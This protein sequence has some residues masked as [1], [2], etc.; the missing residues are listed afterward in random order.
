MH[1][2]QLLLPLFITLP[3]L[4]LADVK[5]TIPTPGATSQG[6]GTATITW[7]DSGSAP[8]LSDLTNYVLNLCAGGNSAG[9][10]SCGL[11]TLVSGGAFSKG[12]TV[13]VNMPT[14]AGADATNG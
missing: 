4:V 13:T 12:N 5:F 11:A 7:Q 8:A 3:H 6:G 14:N 10:F 9:S 2:R 1:F